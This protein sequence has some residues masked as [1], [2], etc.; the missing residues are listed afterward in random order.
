V[1]A[2]LTSA[3]ARKW[4]LDVLTTAPATYTVV[5]GIAELKFQRSEAKLEEDGEY[6]DEGWG[7]STKTG[8][9]WS[10]EIKA[11]RKHSAGTY[12]PGQQKLKT[13]ALAFGSAGVAQIRIY[14]RDGGAEAYSGYAEVSWTA[15]GG[16]TTDLE[17]VTIVLTGKGNMT[18]IANPDA[19]SGS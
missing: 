5:K 19:E 6:A 10:I 18:D 3:L 12:D 8:L 2:P 7:S 13:L 11:I 15:D 14:D 4:K 9:N 16:S 17:K 1:T